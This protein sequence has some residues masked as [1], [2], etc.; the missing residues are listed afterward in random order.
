[1][2]SMQTSINYNAFNAMYVDAVD[3]NHGWQAL[4][5]SF[6]KL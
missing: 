1:M 3:A 4:S 5:L 6:P 2:Q